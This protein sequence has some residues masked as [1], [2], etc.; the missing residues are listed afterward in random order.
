MVPV[1]VDEAEVRPGG[2][3]ADGPLH[4]QHPGVEDVQLVNLLRRGKGHGPRLRL[5]GNLVKENFPFFLGQF[6][7]VVQAGNFH[8]PGQDDGGGVHRTRQR[9]RPRLIHAAED[10]KALIPLFPLRGPQV[11]SSSLLSVWPGGG[12][13]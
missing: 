8:L 6:L 7:G 12:A 10:G 11:H 3:A 5:S 4:G 1:A 9:A 13:R 2:Q